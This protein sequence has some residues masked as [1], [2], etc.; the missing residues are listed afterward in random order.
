MTTHDDL[1]RDIDAYLKDNSSLPSVDFTAKTLDRIAL[2]KQNRSHPPEQ[3]HWWFLL[4]VA[5]A[6]II[7]FIFSRDEVTLSD[8]DPQIADS[9]VKENEQGFI[10]QSS[11]IDIQEILIMEESLRDFEILFD[12]E[13]LDILALLEE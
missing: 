1:D 12:E 8:K 4:P 6:I 7:A 11:A 3:S 5:A 13:A 2:D 10:A 9:S